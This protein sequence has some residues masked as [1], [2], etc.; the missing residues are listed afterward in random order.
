MKKIW[1]VILLAM[2]CSG[3]ATVKSALPTVLTS[4]DLMWTIPAGTPFKAIQKSAY[5][6]LTEFVVTDDLKIVY[7]GNLLELEQE[8]NAK[9]IKGARTAKTQGALMGIGGSL[10]TLLSGLFAKNIFKKKDTTTKA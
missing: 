9:A 2:L 5:P 4:K 8:A 1:L 7:A 10:L 3:C 6:K